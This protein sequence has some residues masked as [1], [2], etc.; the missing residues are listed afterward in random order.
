M[1][2]LSIR[3]PYASLIAEGI[4]NIENRSFKTK[5]RG[6]FL[7]HASGLWHDR[8]FNGELFTKD[9]FDNISNYWISKNPELNLMRYLRRETI[10]IDYNLPVG[11]II[12]KAR[13]VDCVQNH[14]SVW[15][16]RSEFCP[17]T[18]LPFFMRIKNEN[19]DFVNTYGGPFDSYTIPIQDE[20]CKTEYIRQR[21]C[22]DRG[23]WVS[24]ES[25]TKSIISKDRKPTYNWVLEDPVLFDKPILNVKGKL[26][27]WEY[28]IDKCHCCNKTSAQDEIFQCERCERD[29]CSDCQAPYNQFSQID[30]NCCIDCYK[31]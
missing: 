19:G 4:K 9:Q 26:S 29:M 3:Q 22:H 30:F 20:T 15:A 10:G 23:E 12:G 25:I 31:D 21:F 24:D 27:F 8:L 2:T 11:A 7:I 6:E 17:I 16:E 1:K 14:D 28:D 13:L 18:G 5:F